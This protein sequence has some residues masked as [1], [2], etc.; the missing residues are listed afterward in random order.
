MIKYT[1]YRLMFPEPEDTGGGEETKVEDTTPVEETK[2]EGNAFDFDALGDE[3]EQQEETKTE[4]EPSNDDY[5]LELADDLGLEKEE[6]E[7]FTAAAKK[8]GIDKAAA[9]GMVAEFTKAI[10]ENV[11]RVRTE[12]N[13][14]AEK[15]LRDAW[16]SNFN[17]NVKRAG[18]L[19][20]RVGQAAGWS[21][22][23][24]NS[25]KNADSIRVFYDIA[26]VMG[27]GK[28]VGLASAPTAATT[29]MTKGDIERELQSVVSAF[30]NA[31]ATGNKDEAQKC[32]DRHKEL[33][34]MLTGRSGARILLP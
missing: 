25:F 34:K 8:Y 20:K 13:A 27:S 16:G 7:I 10:N 23:L 5:A 18:D 2:T 12:D 22:E 31:K 3:P 32:S 21:P 26:R 9:S 11:Q 28:T 29:P 30:W 19:V 15:A 17:A 33:Q 24:I 14:K 4:E 6:I 1:Y